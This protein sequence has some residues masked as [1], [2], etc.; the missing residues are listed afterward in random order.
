MSKK[1]AGIIMAYGVVL[2]G[3]GFGIQSVAPELAKTPFL[4]GLIGGGLCVLWGFM[5]LSGHQRRAGLLLTL[6]PIALLILSPT[7]RAWMN[8]SGTI[9]G[10]LV[11]TLMLL[12]TV[13]MLLYVMHGER[14]PE[15]YQ[16]GPT[17]RDGSDA[18]E[19]NSPAEERRQQSKPAR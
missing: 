5:A 3:L 8:S 12:L 16:A 17:R 1:M 13:V 6:A 9:A 2:A 14:S 15:F 10:P 11:L 7:L 19:K 4:T 18:R